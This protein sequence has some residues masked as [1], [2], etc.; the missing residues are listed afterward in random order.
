MQLSELIKYLNQI[1]A[2]YGDGKVETV[3]ETSAAHYDRWIAR[4]WVF[5]EPAYDAFR[6]PTVQIKFR[7]VGTQKEGKQ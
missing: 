4:G 7:P 2:D 3:T 6:Y 1:L 5:L